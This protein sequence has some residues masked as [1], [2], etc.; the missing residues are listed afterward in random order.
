MR[1]IMRIELRW[2][3]VILV[4]VAVGIL[5]CVPYAGIRPPGREVLA[6]AHVSDPADTTVT[7]LPG[8]GAVRLSR[9]H[10]VSF[11]ANSFEPPPRL[12]KLREL[13]N[14]D[15][16]FIM[17]LTPAAPQFNRDV[18]IN[19]SLANCTPEQVGDTARWKIHQLRRHGGAADT[20]LIPVIV[21]DSLQGRTRGNSFFIVAD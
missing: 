1:V 8:G 2:I 5:S 16:G 11:E 10:G 4:V 13:R 9:G 19:I 18:L 15:V 17:A 20:V 14:S 12:L 21:G 6:C 7:V 3:V